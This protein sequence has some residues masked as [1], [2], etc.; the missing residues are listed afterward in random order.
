MVGDEFWA[1]IVGG[2]RAGFLTALTHEHRQGPTSDPRTPNI[3]ADTV[4]TDL[5]ELL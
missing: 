3:T 2:H 1:D 4:I 5:K